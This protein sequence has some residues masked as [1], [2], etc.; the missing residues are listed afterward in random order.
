MWHYV[1]DYDFYYIEYVLDGYFHRIQLSGWNVD[2]DVP[3]FICKQL[4]AELNCEPEQ[5]VFR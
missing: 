5:K 3:T 4:R 2:T 1:E